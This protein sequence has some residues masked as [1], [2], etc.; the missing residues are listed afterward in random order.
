MEKL[1]FSE[2]LLNAGMLNPF[3]QPKKRG[4][5]SLADLILKDFAKE[6]NDGK[7][8]GSKV[9]FLAAMSDANII[10]IKS[11]KRKVTV[12]WIKRGSA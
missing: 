9:G 2:H 1:I 3:W 8:H 12:K 4:R 7:L 5:P 10:P 11:G 6:W